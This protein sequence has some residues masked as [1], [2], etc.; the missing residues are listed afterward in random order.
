EDCVPVVLK[1]VGDNHSEKVQAAALDVLMRFRNRHITDRLLACYASMS[2]G[3]RSRT[4]DLLLSR[5]DSARAFLE[6]VDQKQIAPTDVPVDQL[7]QVTLHGDK[8]LDALVRKHWGSLQ[9]GT[10]EEKLAVMRRLSND[11]RA[12]M[13]DLA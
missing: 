4:R 1:L 9:P 7:R 5:P 11:L 8:D 10:P 12:G 13:G 3:L 2:P 6:A